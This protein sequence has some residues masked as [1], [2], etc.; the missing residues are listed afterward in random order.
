MDV[1]RRGASIFPGGGGHG[2]IPSLSSC[3]LV[4]GPGLRLVFFMRES[5]KST[6]TFFFPTL[7][8]SAFFG[9]CFEIM[10]DVFALKASNASRCISSDC[11]SRTVPTSELKREQG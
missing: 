11:W 2:Y 8:I 3:S 9:L 5:T 4:V 10:N 7:H 1:E 6:L